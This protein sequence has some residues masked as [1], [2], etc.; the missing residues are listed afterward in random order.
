MLSPS[1]PKLPCSTAVRT[2]F[3]REDNWLHGRGLEPYASNPSRERLTSKA[4]INYTWN[5]KNILILRAFILHLSNSIYVIFRRQ[6]V[7]TG[8]SQGRIKIWRLSDDLT[9]QSAREEEFLA[10]IANDAQA[11]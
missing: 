7:A 3:L 10:A 9:N 1:L 5:W 4:K 6:I 11:E 2:L 8:D